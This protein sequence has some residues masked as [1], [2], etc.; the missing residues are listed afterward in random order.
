MHARTQTH[1]QY[2]QVILENHTL[3]I[4]AAASVCCSTCPVSSVVEVDPEGPW[5]MLPLPWQRRTVLIVG[6][7]VVVVDVP[8]ETRERKTECTVDFMYYCLFWR[9]YSFLWLELV[10]IDSYLLPSEH[11]RT[12]WAAHGCSHEGVGERGAALLHD[13][14]SLIH[15]LHRTY[16]E[17]QTVTMTT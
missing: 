12:R 15:R 8:G 16:R 3:V 4:K 11:A 13:A 5:F 9:Y 2:Y 10:P 14:P 6:V 7:G 1:T 17:R